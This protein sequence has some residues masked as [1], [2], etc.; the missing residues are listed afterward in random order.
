MFKLALV[1]FLA[2]AGSAYAQTNG[3]E[4]DPTGISYDIRFTAQ[5]GTTELCVHRVAVGATVTAVD[6]DGD[7]TITQADALGCTSALVADGSTTNSFE[8]EIVPPFT[9]NVTI[10][11]RAYSTSAAPSALSNWHVLR[12]VLGTP[13]LLD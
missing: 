4:H 5:P 12:A 9:A 7:G 8:L 2:L 1:A 11:G 10:A 3:Q 6:T 13:V